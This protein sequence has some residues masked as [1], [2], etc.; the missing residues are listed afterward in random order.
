MVVGGAVGFMVA[1][2][3][4]ALIGSSLSGERSRLLM[5]GLAGFFLIMGI[6]PSIFL[7][8]Q[9]VPERAMWAA[10]GGASVGVCYQLLTRG[11]PDWIMTPVGA[12]SGAF[13]GGVAFFL[14]YLRYEWRPWQRD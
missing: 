5:G 11:G 4:M 8:S 1:A 12:I 2:I 13:V 7:S 3:I 14:T 6:V 10:V 9:S